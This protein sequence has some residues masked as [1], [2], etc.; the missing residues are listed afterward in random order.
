[1][2]DLSCAR[3]GLAR[4]A[5]AFKP[6]RLLQCLVCM[7]RCLSDESIGEQDGLGQYREVSPFADGDV[8]SF[9]TGTA[10]LHFI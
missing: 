4:I 2:A 6:A 3:V 8:H 7:Y 9:G 1:M 10:L 5:L